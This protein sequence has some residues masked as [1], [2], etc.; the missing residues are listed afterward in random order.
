MHMVIDVS[1]TCVPVGPSG[2][3]PPVVGKICLSAPQECG[4][5]VVHYVSAHPRHREAALGTLSQYLHICHPRH[6]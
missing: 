2:E 4:E 6:V 5:Y 1:K 3:L